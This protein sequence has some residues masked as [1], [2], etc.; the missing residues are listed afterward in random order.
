V[1]LCALYYAFQIRAFRLR[2]LPSLRRDSFALL[3]LA[4]IKQYAADQTKLHRF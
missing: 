4:P 2:G 3:H 1:C